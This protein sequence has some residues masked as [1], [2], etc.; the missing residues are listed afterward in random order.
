MDDAIDVLKENCVIEPILSDLHCLLHADDT[1]VLSTNRSMS[2]DKCNVLLD[3]FNTKKIGLNFKKSE[4]MIINGKSDDIRC[5]LNLLDG[6]LCYKQK[7]RYLGSIFTD[8]G[9]IKNDIL[10]FL[11]VK[12]KHVNVKLANFMFNNKYAPVFVKLTKSSQILC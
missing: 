11:S 2:I 8:S 7:H 12:S 1:L 4:Y 6:W 9:N 5:D 10:A 3:T